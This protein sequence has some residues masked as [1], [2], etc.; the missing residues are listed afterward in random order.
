MMP[1]A[2]LTSSLIS[3]LRAL[4]SRVDI[5]GANYKWDQDARLSRVRISGVFVVDSK[6]PLSQPY[7]VIQRG[8]ANYSKVAI[9][10]HIQSDEL[11]T[12][13]IKGD[14]L[15]GGVGVTVGA[16]TAHEASNIAQFIA[17]FMQTDRGQIIHKSNML[18]NFQ[19]VSVGAENPKVIDSQIHRVEVV[20]GINTE[21]ISLNKVTPQDEAP[22]N[23]TE[24]LGIDWRS[25][26]SKG[27]VSG[28][29]LTLG[30]GK[31]V[32]FDNSKSYYLDSNDLANKKYWSIVNGDAYLINSVIDDTHIELIGC[33]LEKE[34]DYSIVWNTSGL[35]WILTKE[36]V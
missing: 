36:N 24:Y 12:E 30:T 27:S 29:V 21:T 11:E 16:R 8:P 14:F 1:M 32:G 5:V 4:F 9:A 10:N 19:V 23:I 7:I 3:Y 13:V 2:S 17:E 28:G 31:T 6:T 26:E 35:H 15:V 20:V 33:S 34:V 18:R 22:F 25:G